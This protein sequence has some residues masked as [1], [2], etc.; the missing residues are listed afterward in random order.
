MATISPLSL[1]LPAA[2][3]AVAEKRFHLTFL[4]KT[5]EEP[6]ISRLI[7][8]LKVE[9]NIRRAN[10]SKESGFIELGIN[11][12]DDQIKKAVEYLESQ[13]VRVDALGGDILES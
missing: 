11:G 10:V 3:K 13:K 5:V 8:Q 7:G 2:T 6:I 4:G 1:P 9:V 12:T